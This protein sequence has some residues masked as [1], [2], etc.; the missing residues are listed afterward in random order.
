VLEL[1]PRI[2]AEVLALVP[3]VAVSHAAPA[4]ASGALIEDKTGLPAAFVLVRVLEGVVVQNGAHMHL[5]IESR[6]SRKA[7][8]IGPCDSQMRRHVYT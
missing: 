2:L 7:G 8:S 1:V 4:H 6:G 3:A 5:A